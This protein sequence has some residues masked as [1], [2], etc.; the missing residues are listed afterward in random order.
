[1]PTLAAVNPRLAAFALLLGG[2][3]ALY[4]AS[5][6]AVRALAGSDP[7]QPGRR[8]VGHWLPIF[9]VAIAATVLRRADVA[10]GVIFATSVA[11]LSLMLGI[12]AY[13]A[14]L[15][16]HPATRRGWP[17]VLPAALLSLLAGF[18]GALSMLHAG[19]LAILGLVVWSVWTEP[20][21]E[22]LEGFGD[23][24]PAR[25]PRPGAA[26]F[27]WVAVAL[28]A[29]G[30]YLASA[31]AARASEWS[32]LLPAGLL[33]AAVLSPLLTMPM[34]AT[35]SAL[36]ERGHSSSMAGTLVAVVLLNICVTL[37]TSVL[38]WHVQPGVT[39]MLSLKPPAV[40]VSTQPEVDE[41]YS[42]V[43]KPLLG[44]LGA[45]AQPMPYPMTV[46]RIDTVLVMVLGFA[47]I[48][49]SLGRWSLGKTEAGGLIVGYAVYLGVTMWFARG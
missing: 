44:V 12:L 35:S 25:E 22:G 46:W 24:P 6:I 11:S 23:V 2:A 33:A 3:V 49:V 38:V 37:P 17:F 39:E 32:R 30:G 21:T 27:F 47:L 26:M 43:E 19:V 42:T 34:L 15:D 20:R 28:S 16:E 45:G 18:T 48:P 10:I 41:R 40:T 14:P 36:A 29:A 4:T 1:M 5:L 31:G 13:F 7:A 8:A 9:A